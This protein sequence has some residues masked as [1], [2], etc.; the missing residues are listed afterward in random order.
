METPTAEQLLADQRT[1]AVVGWLLLG[2]LA[3]AVAESVVS[4]DRAWALFVSGVLVL[5][6]VPPVA[7]WNVEVMLPWEVIGMAALPTFGRAIA[8][9]SLLSELTMY[10][11]VAA[12][13]LIVVVELDLFT[14]VTLTLGFAIVLVVLTTL[15]TAGVWAVLRWQLDLWVG[16]SFFH[17]PGL[18][19]EAVHDELMIEFVYSAVAGIL[20][21]VSFEL[22]VRR[23]ATPEQRVP[24]EVVERE[25]P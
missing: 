23:L 13:A 17:G 4:T 24:P 22:Y 10:L 25:A 3:L 2:F 8:T 18:D 11:S 9:F 7:F 16:T 15:A 19:D 12:L 5:C 1:N 14:P 6:L 20:A 21:G